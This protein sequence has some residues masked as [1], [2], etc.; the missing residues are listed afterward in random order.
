MAHR[1]SDG[2]LSF[3]TQEDAVLWRSG[4]PEMAV[5]LQ[6]EQ[7]YDLRPMGNVSN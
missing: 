4:V 7:W 6:M 2:G 3:K 1:W 5:A